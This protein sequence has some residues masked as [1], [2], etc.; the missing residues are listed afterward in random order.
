MRSKLTSRKFWLAV[1]AFLGSVGTTIAG[2]QSDN[3]AITI[4]GIICASASTAIY[5]ICESMVDAAATGTKTGTE[6]E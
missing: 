1:A 3:E 2:I 5:G 4:T 6:T